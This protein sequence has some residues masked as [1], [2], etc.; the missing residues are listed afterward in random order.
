[1]IYDYFFNTYKTITTWK[2]QIEK[3]DIITMC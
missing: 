1:M 3:Q 2:F